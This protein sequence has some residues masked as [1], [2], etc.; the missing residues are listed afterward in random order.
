MRLDGR[1]TRR[2]NNAPRSSSPERRASRRQVGRCADFG[3]T[4]SGRV[5]RMGVSRTRSAYLPRLAGGTPGPAGA[6]TKAPTSSRR[7]AHRSSIP[8]SGNVST[9]G[10]SLGGLSFHVQG[11]DGNY[12]YG[13]H[14]DSYSGATGHLPAGTV[15]GYVG[16]TGNAQGTHLHFEI[17]MAAAATD[18]PV[19]HRRGTADMSGPGADLRR[20]LLG[21]FLHGEVADVVRLSGGT[22]PARPL[23][24]ATGPT[25]APEELILQR[26]P[27]R[28]TAAC[29]LDGGR[30]ALLRAAGAPGV[31]VAPVV[32]DS[33]DAAS[34]RAVHRRAQARAAR[35]SPAGY[36]GTI[37][38]RGRGRSSSARPQALAR[39]HAIPPADGVRPCRRRTNWE[40]SS[41]STTCLRRAWVP[42]PRSSS[43]SDSS[44]GRARRRDDAVLHGDFRLGNLLVDASGLVGVHRLGA[45][46]PRRPDRGPGVVLRA[47]L[48]VRGPGRSRPGLRLGRGAASAAYERASGIAWSTW[49]RCVGGRPSG[50]SSGG[51]SACSRPTPT[52]RAL[53]LGR[54]GDDR[55]PGVRERVGPALRLLR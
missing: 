36:C 17:H 46:P 20:R 29:V 38:L 26:S 35:R 49:R 52:W 27:V 37:A 31:P 47:G 6:P 45:G 53:P 43:G 54:A 14:L 51:S 21:G 15:V 24:F 44:N 41:G 4:A 12:Y 11:D 18:Q 55:P 48:A 42:I 16:D 23:R 40:R 1:T 22:R 9:K 30:G 33:S 10:D 13:T 28:S 3:C 50:P 2:R 39:I 32:A 19:S 5:R 8:V 7:A 34:G 25:T